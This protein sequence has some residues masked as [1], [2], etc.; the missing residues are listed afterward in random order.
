MVALFGSL[1][2][3]LFSLL[4]TI[5]DPRECEEIR[6]TNAI[7]I[8]FGVH[9]STFFLLLLSYM[10]PKC[11][12]KTGR[13]MSIFYLM[14]VAAMVCVQVIFFHGQACNIVAPLLYYWLFLNIAMFYIMI[15][16]GLSLWAAYICWE[17]DEEEKMI[18]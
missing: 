18:N 4:I 3:G 5:L 1:I 11:I 12:V 2:S 15:A 7:Y 17:V 9:V 16:F 8:C 13:W 10:C 6:L 14:I